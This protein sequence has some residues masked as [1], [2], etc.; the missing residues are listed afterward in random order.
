[1]GLEVLLTAM[2][3]FALVSTYSV[4]VTYVLELP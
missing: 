2:K 4:Y 3:G 1:M